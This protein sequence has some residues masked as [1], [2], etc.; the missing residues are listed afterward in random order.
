V[1]TEEHALGVMRA[2]TEN[3][4]RI[5]TD[6]ALV[7]IDGTELGSYLVPALTTVATPFAA[8]GAGAVGAVLDPTGTSAGVRVHP[9]TL[10]VRRSCGCLAKA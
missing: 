1:T 2:A 3:G 7:S 6:L 5:G 10:V 4:R 8:I 9:M